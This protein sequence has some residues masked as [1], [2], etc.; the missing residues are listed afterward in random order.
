MAEGADR[1]AYEAEVKAIK[2]VYTVEGG[3]LTSVAI[4]G[5][6][7][8][9][10]LSIKAENFEALESGAT[11]AIAEAD[12]YVKDVTAEEIA[13]IKKQQEAEA[14]AA[15]EAKKAA[16]IAATQEAAAG[17]GAEEIAE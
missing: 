5:S 8:G 2:Y 9:A 10:P 16:E 14:K 11:L 12:S 3:K 7:N 13:E 6:V 15:E 4:E 17:S 1:A